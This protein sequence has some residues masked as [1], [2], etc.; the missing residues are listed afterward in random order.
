MEMFE[1]E[2]RKEGWIEV[3]GVLLERGAR[4]WLERVVLGSRDV[5]EEA[6]GR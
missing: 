1:F 5:E 3:V 4:P 2:G 6:E